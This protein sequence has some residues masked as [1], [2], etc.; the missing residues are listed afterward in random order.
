[1]IDLKINI[2]TLD[3]LIWMSYRY[4]IG[5]HTIAAWYHA[6]DIMELISDNKDILGKSKIEM[7]ISDIRETADY[8][9][10]RGNTEDLEVWYSTADKIE[11]LIKE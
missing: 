11:E 7:Y 2:T 6:K 1:M 4:A 3:N 9:K 10:G 8:C 5:R